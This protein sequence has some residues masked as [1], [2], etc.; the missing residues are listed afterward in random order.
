VAER[1][2]V[3][4]LGPQGTFSEQALLG[5]LL[6]ER[7]QPVA[8]ETVYE[9][10]MAVHDGRLPYALVPIENSIE[11]PVTVTLDTLAGEAGATRI[12]GELVLAVHHCL[13]AIQA[14]PLGAYKTILTHPQPAGQCLRFLRRELAGARIR[15]CSST[16]EAVR[17]LSSSPGEPIAAIGTALAAEIYGAR[18][19]R[20]NIEDRPDNQT[21]FVWL[22]RAGSSL[23]ELPLREQPAGAGSKTSLVFWGEG[24][25]RPGWLVGCLQELAARSINLTK[26]ES[27]PRRERLGH[28][29]FFVDLEG[30]SGEEHVR[31]ALRALGEH[32]QEVRI[33]GTYPA[34]VQS[35][36][37][38]P[39]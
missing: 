19:I 39:R 31:E 30:S 26:I 18:V 25:E 36:E 20:A 14:L 5:A 27:R 32:C 35:Q 29:M 21:R 6:P 17:L 15:H 7:V 10:V 16:A 22:A 23:S 12:I 37:R 3:G 33:L 8:C 4:Y 2:A 1:V 11:G 13:I 24:A 9:A 38:A 28:Y 34:A